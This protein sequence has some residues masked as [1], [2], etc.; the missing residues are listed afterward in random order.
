MSA[1]DCVAAGWIL[2]SC[3]LAPMVAALPD[4]RE[5]PIYVQSDLAERDDRRGITT[6]TGDVEIDQGSLQIKADIVK[7]HTE[8]DEVSRI[9]AVGK[10]AN[11]HQQPELDRAV[12]HAR[13]NTITY[14][15]IEEILILTGDAEVD[16]DGTIVKGDSI[17]YF[18]R[19]QRVKALSENDPQGKKRVQMVIPP[20]RVKTAGDNAEDASNPS[21]TE[22][23]ATPQP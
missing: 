22:N 2:L 19:E 4:D 3:A 18:I 12:V 15:V 9:I 5:Q 11:M 7:I 16:Q 14:D 21:A 17:S 6:Y 13:G 20:R 1:R 23:E 10:P 8:D